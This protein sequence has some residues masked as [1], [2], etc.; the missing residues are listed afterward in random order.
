MDG[1]DCRQN[2]DG[3]MDLLWRELLIL[4]GKVKLVGKK[5]KYEGSY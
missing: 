3:E 4:I 2:I 5:I 1:A